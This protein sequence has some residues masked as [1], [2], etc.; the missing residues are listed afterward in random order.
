MSQQLDAATYALMRAKANIEQHGWC[1][2]VD[3]DE[4]G[5]FCVLGALIDATCYG[6]PEYHD[7][8][9][10]LQQAIGVAAWC[11]GAG[12]W[13]WNDRPER[14]ETD[15]LDLFDKAIQLSLAGRE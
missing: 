4:E 11:S 9:R 7:G 15:V 14:T 1:Q 2:Q 13:H 3:K 5:R 8:L 10:C 12:V 6:G